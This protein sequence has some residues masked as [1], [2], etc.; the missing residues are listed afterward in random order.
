MRKS[1]E[2]KLR[3]KQN[4]RAR[5]LAQAKKRAELCELPEFCPP[6]SAECSPPES[7]DD[8]DHAGEAK[9]A[10]Y[11]GYSPFNI[12]LADWIPKSNKDDENAEEECKKKDKRERP[13]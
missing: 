4:E 3:A 13:Y 6:P 11:I 7:D 2:G 1:D 10:S 9:C 12:C 5:K 8:G